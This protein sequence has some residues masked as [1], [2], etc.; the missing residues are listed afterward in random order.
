MKLEEIY[1]VDKW[2]LRLWSSV[3]WLYRIERVNICMFHW[4]YI[5][6]DIF[7][8]ILQI[9]YDGNYRQSVVLCLSVVLSIMGTV[10]WP[11]VVYV[12]WFGIQRLLYRHFHKHR[13][14]KKVIDDNFWTGAWSYQLWVFLRFLQAKSWPVF[15]LASSWIAEPVGIRIHRWLVCIFLQLNATLCVINRI[16]NHDIDP[17]FTGN[18]IYYIHIIMH[19]VPI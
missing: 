6:C 18:T 10:H 8:S 17:Y 11:Y 12:R 9:H 13:P 16:F 15:S 5:H 14:L 2:W 3:C 7:S 4:Y 1:L 19:V